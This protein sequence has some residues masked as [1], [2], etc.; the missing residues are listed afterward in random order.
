[1]DGHLNCHVMSLVGGGGGPLTVLEENLPNFLY[2][3]ICWIC[4]E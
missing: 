2:L 4:C 3:I 1:M